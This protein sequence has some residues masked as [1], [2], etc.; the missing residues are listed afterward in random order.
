[1]F[2]QPVPDQRTP[3]LG[4]FLPKARSDPQGVTLTVKLDLNFLP[5][6]FEEP[7]PVGC[8][9]TKPVGPATAASS[10]HFHRDLHSCGLTVIG[11]AA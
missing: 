5:A 4:I 1:M 11:F 7:T 8:P 6:S 10:T 3:D 2:S 9:N